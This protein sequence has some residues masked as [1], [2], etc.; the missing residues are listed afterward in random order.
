MGH[1]FD[2][3]ESREIQKAGGRLSPKGGKFSD[4]DTERAVKLVQD[5]ADN[6]AKGFYF[7]IKT[8]DEGSQSRNEGMVKVHG[9]DKMRVFEI[10]HKALGFNAEDVRDYLL[11]KTMLNDD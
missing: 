7:V 5:I 10:V 6:T 8:T 1:L 2:D 3:K 9:V 11:L 4:G